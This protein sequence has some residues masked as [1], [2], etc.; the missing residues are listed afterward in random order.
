MGLDQETTRL[1]LRDRAL[2]KIKKNFTFEIFVT[3]LLYAT[4]ESNYV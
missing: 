3:H 4:S 2:P 1:S